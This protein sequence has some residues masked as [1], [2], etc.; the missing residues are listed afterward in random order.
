[1]T[2]LTTQTGPTGDGQAVVNEVAGVPGGASGPTSGTLRPPAGAVGGLPEGPHTF[3]VVA[4]DAAGN[5]TTVQR[6]VILDLTGLV[7][8]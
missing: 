3:T 2:S 4:T 5:E 1:M 8:F 7:K 6:T